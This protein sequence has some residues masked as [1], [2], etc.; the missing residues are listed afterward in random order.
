MFQAETY[1]A[2]I[3]QRQM[4]GLANCAHSG[5]PRNLVQQFFLHDIALDRIG[6]SA[7]DRRLCALRRHSG[8]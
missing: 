7:L 3:A 2:C 4:A 1:L 5:Q 6:D 8:D